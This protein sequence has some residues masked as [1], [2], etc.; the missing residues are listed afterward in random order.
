MKQNTSVLWNCPECDSKVITDD[1]VGEIFCSSCGIVVSERM[2]AISNNIRSFSVEDYFNKSRNGSPSKISTFDMGNSSI[3]GSNNID[4]SGNSISREN[5]IRFSRLRLWDSRSKKNSKQRSLFN[6]FFFLDLVANKLNIPENAKEQAAY[7]YRKA[8]EKNIIRGTSIRSMISASI[9]ASCK[10]LEIPRSLDDVAHA[11]NLLRKT[12]SRTYR[13]LVHKLN[14]NIMP[15]NVDYVS[16]VASSV[17]LGEK[18]RRVAL[19]IL[20][21]AKNDNIHIGKNPVGLAVA[22]VYISAIGQGHNISM[23]SLSKKNNISTVTIR[24]IARMLKPVAVKYIDSI[25]A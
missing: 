10:Q 5:K 25:D 4:A 11:S 23:A 15:T 16:K 20:M 6:A 13:R 12:L 24:N 21:D 8:I 3:I 14:L 19:N 17:S 18:T 1:Q 22:S 2:V 7:I 9:Y